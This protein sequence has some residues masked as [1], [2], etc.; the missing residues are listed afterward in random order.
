MLLGG[1]APMTQTITQT[2]NQKITQTVIVP[3]DG[4]VCAVHAL[5][6]ARA[7]A[8]TFGGRLV[9]LRALERAKEHEWATSRTASAEP[10]LM[11]LEGLVQMLGRE[12]IAAEA[13]V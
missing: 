4:S 11:E 12:G 2:M 13:E 10:V 3:L 9:L 7:A 8:R 1:G 5:P 6:F